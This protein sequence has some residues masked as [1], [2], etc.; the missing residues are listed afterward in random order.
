[1]KLI[2]QNNRIGC[3]VKSDYPKKKVQT[4]FKLVETFYLLE[5][6]E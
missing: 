4:R 1:M 2:K 3:D 5:F 6:E